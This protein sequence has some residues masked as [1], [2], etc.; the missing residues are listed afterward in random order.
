MSNPGLVVFLP[1]VG[2]VVGGIK[3][4]DYYSSGMVAPWG[5]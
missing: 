4:P 5:Y 2:A 1:L 3:S